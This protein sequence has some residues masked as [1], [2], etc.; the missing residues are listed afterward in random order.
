MKQWSHECVERKADHFKKFRVW[1]GVG[2]EE[3]EKCQNE[4]SALKGK[5]K[6]YHRPTSRKLMW[7]LVAQ[8]L[9]F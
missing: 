7:I 9:V 4:K 8:L 2:R 1:G 5:L 6:I 3:K